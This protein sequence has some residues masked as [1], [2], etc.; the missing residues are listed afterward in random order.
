MQK[1]QS[2]LYPNRIILI[3]DLAGF[4]VENKIVYTRNVKIY[5]GVTNVIE[6]DIQNADQKRLSLGGAGLDSLK[7]HVMDTSGK[8]LANSPY[9]VTA[10]DQAIY[11]GLGTVSIPKTDLENLTPQ[12]L[13]YSVINSTT[14]T[15]LYNDSR[16][17]ALGTIELVGSATPTTRKS[18][19][20]DR[21][22]GE[23]NF[24]GNVLNHSSAIPVK[25]YEAVVTT[26]INITLAV[27][28][29]IATIKVEGTTDSTLSVE[30]W[31]NPVTMYPDI[32]A[33]TLTNSALI[34][35]LTNIDPSVNYIRVTWVYPDV[36]Q[37]GSQ[38]NPVLV[39]GSVDKIT[40]SYV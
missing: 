6:F 4:T 37:Y 17:G 1:I 27:T 32:T 38:Q 11:K 25:F 19:I 40:V 31:K 23:I 5:Q 3:A 16:F 28:S 26:S 18:V 24:M 21:F 33:S 29:L 10:M 9:T 22:S 30:S 7:I 2:Y 14:D 36:W 13:K 39:Y 34:I 12:F 8:K 15:I 35:P 20:Y